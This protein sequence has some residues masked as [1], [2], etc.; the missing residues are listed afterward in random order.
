MAD[1]A[2]RTGGSPAV[3]VYGQPVLTAGRIEMLPHLREQAVSVSA[4]R[5]GTPRRYEI[6]TLTA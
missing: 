3:A 6:P 1:T 5:F 2:A 4:H